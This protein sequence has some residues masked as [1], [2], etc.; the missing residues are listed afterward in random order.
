MSLFRKPKSPPRIQVLSKSG[1]W[2]DQRRY[3]DALLELYRSVSPRTSLGIGNLHL[4]VGQLHL[5]PHASWKQLAPPRHIFDPPRTSATR[6]ELPA[7]LRQ[8]MSIQGSQFHIERVCNTLIA[9]VADGAFMPA[10]E[11]R[12]EGWTFI[13]DLGVAGQVWVVL[14]EEKGTPVV[15]LPTERITRDDVARAAPGAPSRSGFAARTTMRGRWSDGL[16]RVALV[17]S[18]GDRA[19]FQLTYLRIRLF[20]GRVTEAEIV[21]PDNDEVLQAFAQFAAQAPLAEGE[22]RPDAA[23]PEPAQPVMEQAKPEATPVTNGAEAPKRKA[24]ANGAGERAGAAPP[25]AP[26]SGGKR[27]QAPAG[28]E[29]NGR[30]KMPDVA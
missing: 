27:P 25:A 15:F 2:V 8:W 28:Q 26:K 29:R 19:G 3:A 21:T 22:V 5:L 1:L 24:A 14:I 23:A 30:R 11:L 12:I 17:N 16:H 20:E 6:L 9:D 13:P 10:D 4:D 7:G 18:V